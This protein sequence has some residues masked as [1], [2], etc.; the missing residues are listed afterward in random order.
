MTDAADNPRML[1]GGQLRSARRTFAVENPATLA[2]VDHAPDASPADLDAAV[3]AARMAFPGWAA[4][5]LAD[6]RSALLAM[7]D[8]LHADIGA[9]APLLTAEQGKTRAEAEREV[10]SAAD[11]LAGT[12]ALPWD[13]GMVA[14]PAGRGSFRRYL[15]MGV[16]GAIVPWNYPLHIAVM[17]LAS[18][19]L[20]GNCVVLKPSPVTPLT[21]L[22]LGTIAGHLLPPG[23]LNI[24]SGSDEL[25]SW[26]TA[27]P[28]V[29]KISFTGSTATG[30]RVMAAAAPTLKRLTLELGG[31]D[32]AIVLPGADLDAIAPVLFRS[33]FRN[34]GQ[35]CIATKRLYVHDSLYDSML[36]RLVAMARATLVGDGAAPGTH[37][38]PVATAAQRR[39]I[40]ALRDDAVRRGARIITG[41]APDG[42]GHFLPIMLVENPSDEAELVRAEQFGPI[43]PVLRFHEPQTI[44]AR[45]NDTPMALGCSIWGPSKAALDTARH[46]ICGTVWINEAPTLHPAKP[47]G[48][49]GQSG[50]GLEG[51]VEGLHACSAHQSIN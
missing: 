18:A 35:V 15:P 38:G 14:D 31:N 28:G 36:D 29:D 12:A 6:R 20:A 40:V 13:T 45:V 44:A 16:V 21:S 43:L 23:V 10:R 49:M 50:F 1:I 8:S 3:A 4:T 30:R 47:F 17:K 27:H 25:G 2:V 39:Q 41:L 5:P 7:A 11:W 33:A 46:I 34:A 26:L 51:G 19:L 37:M 9:M 48:G 24:L 42:P 32:A 22:R